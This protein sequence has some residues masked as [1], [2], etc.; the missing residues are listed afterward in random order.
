MTDYHF[1]GVNY[2]FGCG[3]LQ[4]KNLVII[5]VVDGRQCYKV[6]MCMLLLLFM[7]AALYFNLLIMYFYCY[8]DHWSFERSKP[9]CFCYKCGKKCEDSNCFVK[10]LFT[11]IFILFVFPFTSVATV[12]LLLP[13]YFMTLGKCC[14]FTRQG[15]RRKRKQKN[16]SVY[17][18]L[19]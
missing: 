9:Y 14:K 12:I 10:I 8:F 3:N 4:C 17:N 18:V 16:R 2:I 15:C 5:I 6:F 13:A 19:E 7:P 1:E 11:A